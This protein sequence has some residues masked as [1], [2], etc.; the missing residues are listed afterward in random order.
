MDE[1]QQDDSTSSL[2]SPESA[3]SIAKP[4][5]K[6]QLKMFTLGFRS[7]GEST[8]FFLLFSPLDDPMQKKSSSEIGSA[9]FTQSQDNGAD[10]LTQ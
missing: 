10:N 5:M 8:S 2:S 4:T 9:G 7:K 1:K 6:K 3:A